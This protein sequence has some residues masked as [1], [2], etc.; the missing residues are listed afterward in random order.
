VITLSQKE[1]QN[2]PSIVDLPSQWRGLALEFRQFAA[3]GAAAAFERAA[4]ELEAALRRQD[5]DVLSASDAAQA[6]GY[7]VEQIRRIL[8]QQPHLN[9]GR[10]GKP[11]IR[12]GDLPRKPRVLARRG[13]DAY[14]A[15][16]DAQSLMS[17]QGA[18]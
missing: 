9:C 17:R 11:A 3:L 13:A 18:V 5:D 10:S 4:E 15:I 2:E 14:D 1:R 8:R 12:R 6:S 7:S 16:A